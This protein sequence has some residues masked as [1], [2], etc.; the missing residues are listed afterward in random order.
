[1]RKLTKEQKSLAN[2]KTG[3]LGT[4]HRS[5]EEAKASFILHPHGWIPYETKFPVRFIDSEGTPFDA[6]PDFFHPATGFYAE[7][8]TRRMN[9]SGSKNQSAKY[10]NDWESN[11]LAG[12]KKGGERNERYAQLEKAWNHSVHKV[13][14]VS[15]QLPSST[16]L[17]VFYEKDIDLNEERRC[18]R[19]GVFALSL[20]NM[21]AF[22]L[23]LKMASFGVVLG[24][25]RNNSV[26]AGN[27][28]VPQ[29]F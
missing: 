17:V 12:K 8:K 19:N 4:K 6:M 20:E 13:A 28:H 9:G 14:A 11:V 5:V 25:R 7:F 16:P 27:G 21:G 24:F 10:M 1:M 18:A 26:Y 2:Q 29:G 15:K 23:F 3:V 22:Q